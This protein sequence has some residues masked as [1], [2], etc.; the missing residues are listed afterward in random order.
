MLTDGDHRQPVSLGCVEAVDGDGFRRVGRPRRQGASVL[1]FIARAAAPATA[2]KPDANRFRVLTMA[3]LI[4]NATHKEEKSADCVVC[5]VC[6]DSADDLCMCWA[7][8]GFV[9]LQ[10]GVSDNSRASD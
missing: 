5:G 4:T 10:R 2:K 7:F 3:D 6:E 9:A 8:G 1:D